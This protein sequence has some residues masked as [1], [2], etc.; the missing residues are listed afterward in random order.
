MWDIRNKYEHGEDSSQKAHLAREKLLNELKAVYADKANVL[1]TDR[2]MFYESAEQ[3]LQYRPQLA[4]VKTWINMV[5]QTIQ[6]SKKQAMDIATN[7]MKKVT[8]YFAQKNVD[9]RT[10]RRKKKDCRKCYQD[11]IRPIFILDRTIH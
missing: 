2:D 6:K 10:V 8:T 5:K 9:Q 1:A 3:H 4:Q 7:G 11:I